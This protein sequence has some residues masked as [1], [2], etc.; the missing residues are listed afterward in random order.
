MGSTP[1]GRAGR[2]DNG[3]DMKIAI[4]EPYCTG[5]HAAW[6]RG[7]ATRS[8]HTVEVFALEGRHWKWRMHGGAVTLARRFLAA[9]FEPDLILASDMCD[10]TT[11]LALT[12]GRTS[13]T[14]TAVYFHEDQLTYTWSERDADPTRGRDAHYAFINYSSS[15]A[16]DLL[17]FNSRYHR[18]VYLA[19][20]PPYLEAFPDHRGRDG[21]EI[22]KNKA[23]V[24]P[25]GLDCAALDRHRPSKEQSGAPLV[26]WNHRWEYDK[27]PEGFFA[28]LFA[29]AGEGLEFEV[30]VLGEH[31]AEV[32]PVFAEARSV[33]GRR[34]VQ[35]GYADPGRYAGWLWRA[36]I[37]PVTSRHDFFGMSVVEAIYCDCYP[38][39]PKRLAYPEHIPAGHHGTFFYEGADDLLRRLR[40][41]IRNID[42]TRRTVTGDFVRRYDWATLAPQ[43]DALFEKLRHA[44]P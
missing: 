11:F 31:F 39:L 17:L 43:Y 30:A 36:D 20:L 4:L 15:L 29:L 21:I 25:V 37:L 7:Y 33:L 42:E 27:N 13:R 44:S 2:S 14:R 3:V 24:L 6:A 23:A 34:I 5:S 26:L 38:L 35:F 28:A 41:R 18:D 32:P 22:I 10:L 19:A 1:R 16:A 9:T 40:E 12:R 8:A